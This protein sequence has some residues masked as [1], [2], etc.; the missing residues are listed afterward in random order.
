[1]LVSVSCFTYSSALKMDSNSFSETKY[2]SNDCYLF[3]SWLTLWLWR[4]SQYVPPKWL[5]SCCLI[6]AFFLSGLLSDH[7]NG[8]YMRYNREDH[9]LDNHTCSD[10]IQ[11]YVSVFAYVFKIITS[12]QDF[13]HYT[14]HISY[15]PMLGFPF[16]PCFPGQ[17]PFLY[18]CP[19]LISKVPLFLS[20]LL[21]SH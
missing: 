4:W 20:I 14:T 15:P 1:M 16:V 5:D 11:N 19:E 13:R 18:K 17:S 7:Q 2:S 8:G 6:I 21:Y 12:I 10:K 3:L 9:N